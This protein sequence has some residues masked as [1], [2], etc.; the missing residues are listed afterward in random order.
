MKITD[1]FAYHIL[2]EIIHLPGWLMQRFR[3]RDPMTWVFGAWHGHA[4]SDNARAVYEY[5][6]CKHPEINA[7][8]LTDNKDVFCSL[9]A[10]NKPVAM[11]HSKEGKRHCLQA[12]FAFITIDARD[13]NKWYINGV[14]Q[15]WLWHGMPLKKIGCD[16]DVMATIKE[17]IRF[18][19]P[20]YAKKPYMFISIGGFWDAALQSA[21]K[22]SAKNIIHTGLP[23]NDAFFSSLNNS[24]INS[25]KLRHKNAIVL[26]YMPTY[27]DYKITREH[28]AYNPFSDFCFDRDKFVQVLEEKNIIFLYKGHF[29]DLNTNR[30]HEQF[31]ERF[32]VIDDS[33]YNNLYAEI[34][35]V[36]VL[37]TDYSSIYFDF[38][39]LNKPVIL[40]PFDYNE[41]LQK[42]RSLYFDYDST[43]IGTK[44]YNWNELLQILLNESYEVPKNALSKY[45]LHHDG[46][47]AERV[48]QLVLNET[49][50]DD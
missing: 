27:R 8:W 35:N 30:L 39:L 46:N 32:F 50:T 49:R 23:R 19:F 44:A 37:I 17:K 13:L 36:D 33:M 6:L 11:I 16:M 14:K 43:M 48:V 4:Y 41:Y 47:S 3:K 38:L 2:Q 15:I 31:G 5:T 40:A 42:S 29:N 9:K 18:K 22:I 7:V 24:F 26:L 28:Q 21:F 25:I 20:Y 12:G 45:H 34:S 1:T 10:N